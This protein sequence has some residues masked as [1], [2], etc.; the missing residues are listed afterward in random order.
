MSATDNVVLDATLRP[1][2]PLSP[3]VL[4]AVVAIVACINVAFGLTL[5][6]HGAWPVMPF[7]GADVA[8]LAWA[9]RA[10]SIAARRHERVTL[11]PTSLTVERHPARGNPSEI[12]L[13]PYWVRV[14]MDETP[15][16]WSQLTLRSHGRA[17]QVGSFLAP[18]DRQSFAETLKLALRKNRETAAPS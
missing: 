5:V 9:F 11:R 16:H 10:S 15:D 1:N 17:V 4:K 14:H 6:L 3:S 2:Q 7:M 18:Q 12:V 8:L 13:N